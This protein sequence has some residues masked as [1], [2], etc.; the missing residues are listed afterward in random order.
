MSPIGGRRTCIGPHAESS[1][2]EIVIEPE[3][4]MLSGF[5][6]PYRTLTVAD[7]TLAWWEQGRGDGDTIVWLHGLPLDSRSWELQR[8]HFIPLCHNVFI[9]LRGY[10]RSTPLPNTVDV[11][12]LYC[13][14]LIALLDALQITVATIVGFASA[15]HVALRFA[16]RHPDRVGKLVTI[17]ASPRFRVGEDWPWGFDGDDISRFNQL[18]NDG[19]ISAATNAVLDPNRV[20]RDIPQREAETLVA[21]FRPMSLLAG[22]DTLRGFF[23]GIARDDDRAILEEIDCPTLL[24]ASALGQE[25]PPEVALFMRQRIRRACLVELAGADHF[26]F[27]TRPVLVNGL[28]EDFWRTRPTRDPADN[29]KEPN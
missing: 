27:A 6:P 21:F 18:L 10:G 15:G 7:G 23:S 3:P 26:A 29:R 5:K 22:A 8:R 11:T 2:S 25:V 28:I 13:C 20:F 1:L 9:D 4:P 12:A 17:N 16:A 24:I 14:D 19:G